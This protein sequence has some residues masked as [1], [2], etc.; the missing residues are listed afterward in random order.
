M[1]DK[2]L[3]PAFVR[4]AGCQPVVCDRR[5]A[6]R[7][8]EKRRREHEERIKA[9]HQCFVGRPWLLAVL[10][11]SRRLKGW[12]VG[13]PANSID[14]IQGI[15]PGKHASNEPFLTGK[16]NQHQAQKNEQNS[17]AGGEQHDDATHY[18]QQPKQVPAD[19]QKRTGDRVV[20]AKRPDYGAVAGE[21]IRWHFHDQEP[22]QN[23]AAEKHHGGDQHDP[24]CH[25][26]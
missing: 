6:A 2:S 17:L 14:Y 5:Q 8:T 4:S 13:L 18:Q 12:L 10:Q 19:D 15:S 7:T 25:P 20:C 22:C 23:D 1:P 16:V 24:Y 11:S 21:I 26:V 9:L 3:I